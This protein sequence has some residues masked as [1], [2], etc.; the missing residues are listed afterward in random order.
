MRFSTEWQE[1]APN[2]APEE[3]ETVA[4]LRIWLDDRNVCMHLRGN[5]ASDAVTLPLY[6]L[7]E[8]LVHDW[9]N[10]F[11]GRDRTLSLV[12][13]REGFAL[14]DLR[15][16]F[17][18]AFL[19]V[20]ANQKIYTNPDIRF[21]GG[22]PELLRRVDAEAVLAGFVASVLDR[23]DAKGVAG[24]GAALRWKR[25][26]KSRAD[27]EESAFCEAAGAL[28]LDPYLIDD[29]DAAA[30]DAASLLFA[31][32]PLTEF[33]AGARAVDRERLIAW[34][35]AAKRRPRYKYQLA[36][37]RDI[38]QQ[39]AMAVPSRPG[40]KGWELGYRRARGARAA[41]G[42]DIVR[43]VRSVRE[44]ARLFGAGPDFGFAPRADGIR[45]LREDRDDGICLHLRKGGRTGSD[46]FTLARGIGDAVCFPGP[47]TAPV[48]D[49]HAAF[50]QA[51]GRAFAAEFLAP[52]EEIASMQAD[53][54]DT[55]TIADAFS[56]STAVIEWQVENRTRV[57]AACA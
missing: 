26:C 41:L 55:L 42:G 50:R 21:W 29:A 36:E 5:L 17:D 38:A 11:G 23:L 16:S 47:D 28:G 52:V 48:N 19:Q 44:L 57:L 53:G 51:S 25:V 32:E 7:A 14:P 39:V 20:E 37:L 46:P 4:D 1:D 31:G 3:R 15:L 43:P 45:L 18:G 34:V 27:P 12:R 22:P 30:I 40:E 56:V 8:G 2:I 9:W 49:L 54:H 24:T 13:H 6:G 10:L 33:L 35:Q